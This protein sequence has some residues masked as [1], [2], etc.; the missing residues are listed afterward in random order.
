VVVY[1]LVDVIYMCYVL[2]H[3]IL[4][5]IY[6]YIYIYMFVTVESKKNKN[7]TFGKNFPSLC[8]PSFAERSCTGRSA[9]N[10]F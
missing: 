1:E 9:K 4:P 6:I 2:L 8:V 3:V 5:Y 7:A 10:F